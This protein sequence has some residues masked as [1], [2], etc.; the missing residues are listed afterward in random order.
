MV[1]DIIPFPYVFHM[2][3]AP[4]WVIA[5]ESSTSTTSHDHSSRTQQIITLHH[6]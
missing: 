3:G 2:G 6:N 1:I 4:T 5:D